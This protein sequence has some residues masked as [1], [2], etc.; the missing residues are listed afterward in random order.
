MRSLIFP[1]MLLII[2][3]PAAA[4]DYEDKPYFTAYVAGNNYLELGKEQAINVVIQNNARLWKQIYDSYEE[5]EFVSKNPDM[6][7]TAYNV[8]VS[9]ESETLNVKTP[10]MRFSAIPPFKPVQIPVIIDTKGVKSGTHYLKIEFSYECIDEIIIDTTSPDFKSVPKEERKTYNISTGLPLPETMTIV[11]ETKIVVY[12]EYIKI[13]YEE[14]E[15]EILLKLIVEKP[16]VSLEVVNVTSELVAGGKG[17]VTVTLKNTGRTKAEKLFVTLNPPRGFLVA[18]M[19]RVDIEKYSEALKQF[20]KMPFIQIPSEISVPPEV[21]TFLTSSAFYVGDLEPNESVNVTFTVEVN[22]DEGG[23]Y[24]FQIKGFYVSDNELKETSTEN[25][26]VFVEEKPEIKIVE[27]VSNVHAG[28]KGDVVVKMKADRVLKGV[29]A[30]LEVKPPLTALSEEY[31]AGDVKEAELRFKVKA[32]SDAENTVYPA[33]LVIY[34]DLGK[35]VSEEFDIG[36]EIKKKTRFEV[37]GKGV[38]E[39][40]REGIVRVAIKNLGEYEIREATARITVVDPF[41]TTD[42]T[43]YIG[44]LKPGEAKNVTFKIKVDSDATPKVYAL[45]LEVKYKDLNDEWVISEPVKLPIEVRESKR[46]PGFGIALS[47]LALYIAWR[48]R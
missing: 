14:K 39:A 11:N 34:H 4:L 16:E 36:I 13:K 27:V 23:Y 25:F 22:V 35:E 18:G 15:Q 28:S 19:E 1:L 40:G 3:F 7:I 5:Y 47:A 26:G 9:F 37:I 21:K 41:S 20:V 8:S 12:P 46:I 6:L 38:L 43:S 32:S 31:F 45:N 24:P 44:S 42:D 33:K 29:K 2:I 30:K 17:K 10:E 48:R